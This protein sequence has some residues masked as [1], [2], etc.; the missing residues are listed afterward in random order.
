M[1][2]ST[3]FRVGRVLLFLFFTFPMDTK[4]IYCEAKFFF[5]SCF[6]LF[7]F[8]KYWLAERLLGLLIMYLFFSDF[9]YTFAFIK[10]WSIFT[11]VFFPPIFT[12]V[13]FSPIFFW[14]S[15]PSLLRTY[16]YFLYFVLLSTSF[17]YSSHLHSRNLFCSLRIRY[18]FC[19][20]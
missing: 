11:F 6:F 4:S 9:C 2:S 5:F 10:L 3:N 19:L 14:F 16:V 15:T 8:C 20:V 1:V 18:S 12:F 17:I 13:F 7:L